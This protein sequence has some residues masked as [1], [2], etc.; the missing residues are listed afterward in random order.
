MGA[1]LV[2]AA[3]LV[4]SILV[5]LALQL[6]GKI[7]GSKVNLYIGLLNFGVAGCDVMLGW[8]WLAVAMT[9]LGVLFVCSWYFLVKKSAVDK[10]S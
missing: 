4:G 2:A 7:K 6:M 1:V 5:V 10:N 9:I 3:M 8:Y